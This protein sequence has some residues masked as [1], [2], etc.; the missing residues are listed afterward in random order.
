L[1]LKGRQYHLSSV[2]GGDP[3]SELHSVDENL[4]ANNEMARRIST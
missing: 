3:E 2:L 1:V 4:E